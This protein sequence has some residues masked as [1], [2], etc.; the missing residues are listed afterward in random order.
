MMSRVLR[1]VCVGQGWL[2]TIFNNLFRMKILT[3]IYLFAK[4]LNWNENFFY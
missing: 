3:L 1:Q 2:D 4:D